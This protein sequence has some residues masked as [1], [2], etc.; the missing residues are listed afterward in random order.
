MNGRKQAEIETKSLGKS[1]ASE[2]EVVEVGGVTIDVMAKPSTK[3]KVARSGETSGGDRFC[4]NADYSDRPVPP[5]HA[6]IVRECAGF[7]VTRDVVFPA[8]MAAGRPFG[9]SV[10]VISIIYHAVNP[11]KRNSSYEMSVAMCEMGR[12]GEHGETDLILVKA[13]KTSSQ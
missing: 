6:A 4:Q 7:S 12:R 9:S 8:S 5:V 2:I 11:R 13:R 3:L 10:I 1:E